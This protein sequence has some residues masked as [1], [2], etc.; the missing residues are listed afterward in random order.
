MADRITK[1][2]RSR[3]M[4]AIRGKHTGPEKTMRNLLR[5]AKIRYTTYAKGLPGTPDIVLKGHKIAVFVDGD[6]W[7]GYRFPAWRAKLTPFW[8]DKI[9]TNIRRDRRNF[10]RL[11][12]G[13][14]KVIRVWEHEL[15]N[16][17]LQALERIKRAMP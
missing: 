8:K 15:E 3:V 17:P 16:R 2:Q 12:R 10:Q 14:W 4:A 11:R 1:E 7:H 9:E 13:G 5:A 6:F